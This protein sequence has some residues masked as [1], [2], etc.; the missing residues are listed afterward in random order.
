[1]QDAVLGEEQFNLN[2]PK[3]AKIVKIFSI[4]HLPNKDL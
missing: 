2:A 1:M 4:K 3:I